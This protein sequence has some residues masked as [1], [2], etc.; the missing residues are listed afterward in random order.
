MALK[1][2][3]M[4]PFRGEPRRVVEKLLARLYGMPVSRVRRMFVGVGSKS[5]QKL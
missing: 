5:V 4:S 2:A 1:R 3:G